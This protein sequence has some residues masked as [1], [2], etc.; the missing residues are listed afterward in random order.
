VRTS[1]GLMR[2][3]TNVLVKIETDEG[4]TGIGESWTNFPLWA[5][6]ERKATLLKGLRPLL[7]GEDPRNISFLWE[8]MHRVLMRGGA[9]LQWG[10]PGPLMQAISG[11]DIAL[12]DILG[13]SIGAPVF[14][15][16]GGIQP[17]RIAAYASG[18]GPERFEP[19][20]E[21]ALQKGYSAFKLKVG[22]GRDKDLRNLV[23]MREIIGPDR[24]LMIDANQAWRSAGEALDHLNAYR[25]FA[26][27]LIEEPVPADRLTELRKIREQRIAPIAGGENVYGRTGFRQT[28]GAEALD[29][30]QPDLTKTGG[31]SEA[32]I[33]CQMAWAWEI[34]YAPHMFGTAVGLAASLHLLASTPNGLCMEVDANPNPLMDNLLKK[35]PFEFRE[36][37]FDFA[38]D[39]PGLGIELDKEVVK[40]FELLNFV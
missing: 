31:I 37:G 12:W 29:I 1:F 4:I 3:R 26:L 19:Y 28:L 2:S 40:E 6:E 17:G 10:A 14:R 8:K 38:G 7:I 22:F 32:R 30:V 27:S 11:V 13:K 16:L 9:G 34:P 36:G 25:D 24:R 5:C 39:L 15:L 20:V 33:I 18:L 35:Q 21:A 23:R